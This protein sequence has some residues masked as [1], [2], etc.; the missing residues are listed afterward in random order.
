MGDKL[1]NKVPDNERD[2]VAD[3]LSWETKGRQMEDKPR[4]AK[5]HEVG[6]KR[7]TSGR[8]VGDKRETSG[9]QVTDK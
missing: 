8:Q 3:K 1:G 9:R 4:Q 2:T 7:K 5:F 6:D